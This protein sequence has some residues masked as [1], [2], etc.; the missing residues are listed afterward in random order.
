MTDRGRQES[1]TIR[2]QAFA[3]VVPPLTDTDAVVE[4]NRCLFC[5]DAPCTRA[6]PTSIDVASFIR[7]IATGNL[8]GSARVILAA[9]PLGGTCARVCPVEEMCEGACVL[10]KEHHPIQIGRLQRHSTD[11]LFA[12][13]LT[14]FQAAQ[15]APS[16][17]ARVAIVGG[18]P[19]GLTA[20]VRLAEA[21][22][23]A[24]IF[25]SQPAAGGLGAYGIVSYRLPVAVA[26]AEVE[27][28][29]R[30]GVEI[31]TGVRVGRDHSFID[32]IDE[33][34][35]VL[36]AFGL[37]A[38]RPLGIPGDTLPGVL[39][40]LQFIEET[41]SRPLDE[42][43]IGE[44]VAVIGA[45]NTAID[46]A[47]AALRL[48]ATSVEILYRRSE[49]EMPAYDFEFD[50]ARREGVHFRWLTQ[51]KRILGGDDPDGREGVEAIECLRTRLGEPDAAGRCRPEEIPGS[52]FTLTV[53][54]VIVA[55]GQ[56]RRRDLLAQCGVE[57]DASGRVGVDPE[58]G[59]T[60][61]PLVYA[62]G[63]CVDGD[64]GATVVQ[65]VAQANRVAAALIARL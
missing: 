24:R 13:G 63:D 26:R 47:T 57:S 35:A 28:V 61:R 41:K 49:V 30:L 60:S 58:S 8:K 1:T 6:C 51:P 23:Q 29:E 14:T 3:E 32:L 55:I 59:E 33:H 44:R 2:D 27:L 7:K 18:G 54:T 12:A 42:I 65:V 31:Q 17:G 4:A 34:D 48:G 38:T 39:R 56:E 52:E 25:E 37:G 46:C 22:V 40:G 62:A 36:L 11:W 19:A 45:G 10:G 53:D 50:F 15:A 20:A 5:Y 9:N 16:G 64:D 43:V 21:G